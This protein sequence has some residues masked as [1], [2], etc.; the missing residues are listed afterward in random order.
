MRIAI[1]ALAV[2]LCGAPVGTHAQVGG[3]VLSVAGVRAFPLQS[4]YLRAGP[5]RASAVLGELA[6]A[7]PLRVTEDHG[8]WLKVRVIATGR[9]G[10]V[11]RPNVSTELDGEVNELLSKN[12]T[13]LQGGLAPP[14]PRTLRRGSAQMLQAAEIW[15]KYGGLLDRVAAEVGIEPAAAIAVIAAESQG[16]A[17]AD[18]HP[19]VRFENHLFWDQWGQEHP[20]DFDQFFQFSRTE[21]RSQGHRYRE[22]PGQSWRPFHDRQPTE[23]SALQVA[24]GLNAERAYRS[25]SWGLTQ[26]LGVH[27]GKLGYG[28]AQAMVDR[29]SDQTV[30]VRLQILAFFDYIRSRLRNSTAVMALRTHDWVSF[31][32]VYNGFGR[33]DE[34]SKRLREYYAAATT[35]LGN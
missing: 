32:Q 28:T 33:E 23:W 24:R 4:I 10:Y 19:V 26:I 30:G 13:L 12:P 20:Q 21:P 15:N 17:F 6:S 18:G 27:H 5:H 25:A 35:V 34:Y 29:F 22:A 11:Y 14:R 16:A 2:C 7:T 3:K 31:A 8:S 9:E 1:L